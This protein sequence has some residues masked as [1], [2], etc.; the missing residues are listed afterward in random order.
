MARAK[1][2]DTEQVL[3]KATSVFGA[4]GYE[5][6]SL[7]ILLKELGIARQSLYDTYGTKHDLFVSALKFYVQQKTEASVL[8]LERSTSVREGIQHLF[9]EAVNVLTDPHRRNECFIINSAVEQAPQQHEIASFIQTNNRWMEN[10]LYT[11]LLRGCAA[12]ELQ[13]QEQELRRI[14]RFLNYTR[15]SLTYA[16]KSGATEEELRELVLTTLMVLD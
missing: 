11:A 1:E 13:F 2:F 9:D 12:G 10:I 14:S 7:S 4:Y 3:R 5:G 15:L 8:L 16:A 6:T